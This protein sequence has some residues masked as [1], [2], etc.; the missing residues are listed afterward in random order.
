MEE[1]NAKVKKRVS[2]KKLLFFIIFEVLFTSVSFTLTVFYGPYEKVKNI[3]VGTS[4]ATFEHKYIAKMFLSDKKIQQILDESSI[5][6]SNP[7]Q[8]EI[9]PD[10]GKIS[11]DKVDNDIEHKEINARKFKGEVLIIHNP[12]KVK[13][14]YSSKIGLEGERT[15]IIAEHYNAIAAINGGGFSDVSPDGKIGSG[16]GAIPIGIVITDG[17]VIYP[18]KDVN[19]NKNQP[20]V[21]AITEEGKLIVGGPYSIN[22][23]VKMKVKEALSFSPTLVVNGKPYISEYS[24][25]GANPRTVIGQKTDGSIIFLTVDGRQGLELGAT[26]KD[27]QDI[28]LQLGAQNAMCMD[29]GASTTM[30]YDGDVI[31]SPCNILGERS[32]PT[33]IYAEK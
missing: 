25:Q 33:I 14:G 27:I 15:S 32:M 7:V 11:V 9:V 20:C 21:M 29:G 30:Y 6:I 12:L 19:F 26:L 31:N 3:V 22:D 24:L 4:M 17:K 28:M 16:I 8:T 18:F 10:I 5:T 1:K 13:V 23:L 2:L